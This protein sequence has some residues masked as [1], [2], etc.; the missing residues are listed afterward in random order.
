MQKIMSEKKK[1]GIMIF[2]I[3]VLIIAG[4][5]AWIN[6]RSR[7][8]SQHFDVGGTLHD[9]RSENGEY[10]QIHVENWGSEPLFV[11]IRLDEYMEIG[12]GA[13]LRSVDTDENTGESI[14]NPQNFAKP[15]IDGASIDDPT[16]WKPHDPT[17][18]EASRCLAGFHD[19]WEWEMGGQRYYF[20]A[21]EE[22]RTNINFVDSSSPA[23]LTADSLNE[24]GVRARRTRL[25]QVQS[26]EWT[27]DGSPVGDFWVIDK[28]FGW[29]YWASPLNPGD[30][31]GLLL[32]KVTQVMQPE[33]DYFYEI[34]VIAQMAT[35]DLKQSN[36]YVIFDDYDRDHFR[37]A[38]VQRSIV[39]GII[40]FLTSTDIGI[41]VHTTFSDR[42]ALTVD[43][44]YTATPSKGAIIT[45][46]SYSI[47]DQAE[48]FLYLADVDG[49]IAKGTLGAA[50]VLLVHGENYIVFTA[51]DSAGNIANYSVLH[52]TYD[53][54]AELGIPSLDMSL[55]EPLLSDPSVLFATNRIRARANPGVRLKQLDSAAES[56]GGRIIGHHLI[57][58]RWLAIEVDS[59]T[60][61]ELLRVCEELMNTGLFY[62]VELVT[63]DHSLPTH[64]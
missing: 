16:T 26:L 39:R 22:Y 27:I 44:T 64:D 15:L 13:G 7:A 57:S 51:R 3:A 36:N 1:L 43:V 38:G 23:D 6:F 17:S 4:S 45:D 37:G 42:E 53:P 35:I 30:S 60:E 62:S 10:R 52:W 34:N 21:P 61:E 29:A 14:P 48:N 50:R 25:A 12:P 63:I 59:Q 24:A 49:M 46:V 28:D 18:F 41:V 20:P 54:Q 32:N 47:N 8:I 56:V 33:E 9:Y 31:T 5:F 11:R 55:V 2:S 58:S 40:N 19:F